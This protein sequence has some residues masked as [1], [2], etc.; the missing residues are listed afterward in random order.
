MRTTPPQGPMIQRLLTFRVCQAYGTLPCYAWRVKRVERVQLYPNSRQERAL[1]FMLDLTRDLYNAALQQRRDAY[2]LRG[3]TVTLKM[4]YA[5][6]TELRSEDPRVA[7][8]YRE[9]L[10]AVLR[11]LDLA[12]TAFFRRCRE[13]EVPGFPRF[14]PRS[15]WRQLQF[16]HG[17]RALKFKEGQRRVYVPGVG[18]VVLRKGRSVPQ[19]FGRGWIVERNG[20]WYLCV[21][22]EV[23]TPQKREIRTVL[24]IDRGVRVLAA[25]SDGEL[26]GNLAVGERR[27]RATARLQ[28]ELDAHTQKDSSGRCL[29]RHDPQRIA[30]VKRLARSK[31]REANA[32]RDYGHK[33]SRRLVD[34]VDCIAIEQLRLRSMT[35][36]AKGTMEKPGRNVQAKAALNRVV[37]DSGFGLLQQMIAYKTVFVKVTPQAPALAPGRAVRGF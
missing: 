19:K 9:C 17:D 29:N 8:V 28:R 23:E 34:S 22:H 6:L 30:A 26:I 7:A 18:K 1:R 16:P 15:R 27:K 14:R 2:R 24:G 5:E 37:L 10:D 4:Q 33:V 20:R 13:G 11:R 25:T 35:R 31:E 36:S 32:R 12:M 21:E 3:I